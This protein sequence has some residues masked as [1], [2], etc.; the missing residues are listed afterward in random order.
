MGQ[1]AQGRGLQPFGPDI[2][3]AAGDPV[4]V[5][6]FAYPTRMAVMRLPG[7]GLVIWSPVALTEDLR[8]SVA[9]LGPVQHIVAPNTLH[10]L[11]IGDWARGFPAAKVHAA[12]GLR[13]KRADLAFDSDLGDAPHADWAGALEQAVIRGNAITT[14]VVFFHAASGTALFTDLLQSYPDDWFSG[15]RRAVARLDRMLEQPPA[16]P[17]KF[18][19]AFTD[20]RAARAGIARVLGWPIERVLMAHGTPVTQDARAYLRSAF[21]WLTG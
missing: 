8:A 20:R 12:P 4:S 18:R 11:F 5:L 10:H 7:G 15:W 3:I 6:G 16:V 14:E 2:W 19:L 9:A 21:G 1:G 17:R 13:A